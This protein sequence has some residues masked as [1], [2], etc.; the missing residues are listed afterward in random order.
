[1]NLDV[2]LADYVAAIRADAEVLA[3]CAETGDLAAPV[4]ACPDWDLRALVMHTG[5]V[6]RWATAAIKNGAAPTVLDGPKP[7]PTAT[8][9]ELGAW[10]RDG[11]ASL[12]DVLAETPL[13]ADTWHPFPYEQKA[14]VWS[15][16]QAMETMVHR[17]DAQA[18][19]SAATS[20]GTPFDPALAAIGLTEYFEML[21]PRA[22]GR[23]Q[24]AAPDVSLHVHCTDAGLPGGAGEWIVWGDNGEY[25]MEAVH[26]KGDAALRGNAS[27]LLLVM[28]GRADL[29]TVD[30]VGDR[31][32]IDAWIALP[33]L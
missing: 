16:R 8:G 10:M 4:A 1:M 11:A 19:I 21:L 33:G 24:T 20:G 3:S 29:G 22:L 9:L 30:L 7:E 6:H 31:S 15:R 2:S 27:D 25:Q 23:R 18:A 5:G 17:W 32:A 28:M 13:D 26:R 12:A 14:W